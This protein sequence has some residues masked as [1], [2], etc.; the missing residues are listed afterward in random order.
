MAVFMN[1]LEME[2]EEDGLMIATVRVRHA[3]MTP[4]S[5][6]LFRARLQS[7]ASAGTVRSVEAGLRD[8]TEAQVER[9]T[10]I[11]SVGGV[12][13]GHFSEV[14]DVVVAVKIPVYKG[15]S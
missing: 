13:K 1:T 11:R 5:V 7:L 15:G 10:E 8:L 14:D 3:K 12:K 4:E 2:P 6:Y 9:L